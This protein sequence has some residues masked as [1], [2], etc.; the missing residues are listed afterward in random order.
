MPTAKTAIS[1]SILRLR[2]IFQMKHPVP[3]KLQI[4]SIPAAL[5]L[6]IPLA[7]RPSAMALNEE[8]P[9]EVTCGIVYSLGALNAYS[10]WPNIIQRMNGDPSIKQIL[11]LYYAPFVMVRNPN[12][13]GIL[14]E[15]DILSRAIRFETPPIALRFKRSNGK[16]AG[17][18]TE[19]PV[20]LVRM[21][22]WR[23]DYPNPQTSY[24]F[25]LS[26]AKDGGTVTLAPGETKVFVPD[27]DENFTWNMDRPGDG[28][29]LFD[30]RCDK[31]GHIRA[32]SSHGW[33]GHTFAYHADWLNGPERGHWNMQGAIPTRSTDKWSV[34]VSL[35]SPLGACR[36]FWYPLPPCASWPVS[37][38]PELQ[39][40]SFPFLTT[41]KIP[42]FTTS[43]ILSEDDTP[44]KHLHL[45]PI[46]AVTLPPESSNLNAFTDRDGNHL[47]DFWE[48][49]H[50]GPQSA[51]PDADP[52]GD[53]L[54]NLGE[55]LAGTSP[56]D[57]D[58]FL[59]A[60]ITRADDATIISW[61]ATDW[62]HYDIQ[63]S[64]DMLHWTTV[65]TVRT[66]AATANL[67]NEVIGPEATGAAFYRI[68]V[69]R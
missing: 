49:A 43:S 39:I 30:W 69:R 11:N 20:E 56:T 8:S 17:F 65:K 25:Y 60:A 53:G 33:R 19:K 36:I 6:L 47:D 34:E 45:R 54:T 21:Y 59:K 18:V 4:R 16:P 40:T 23:K 32:I 48:R 9:V 51:P 24:Q 61:N 2:R 58:D 10:G 5:V 67:A 29:T 68:Q 14:Y 3:H 46:F 42:A 15:G 64:D 27:V 13:H 38:P 41:E 12:D 50:F 44:V 7:L 28:N 66:K 1:N 37:I 55:F 31:T 57:R 35:A 52:D 62:R 26:D 22:V 63:K